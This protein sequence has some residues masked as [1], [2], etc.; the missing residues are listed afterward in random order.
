MS[1]HFTVT[2][3]KGSLERAD[4][5]KQE[6]ENQFNTP[7]SK[8]HVLISVFRPDG[9]A[10]YV[11]R[12][13]EMNSRMSDGMIISNVSSEILLSEFA[14]EYARKKD[15]LCVLFEAPRPEMLMSMAETDRVKNLIVLKNTSADELVTCFKE[16]VTISPVAVPLV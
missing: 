8:V 1:L 4:E 10:G 15:R 6:L 5:I 7:D 2:V 14:L 11:Q 12:M 9:E 16:N 13:V 3:P